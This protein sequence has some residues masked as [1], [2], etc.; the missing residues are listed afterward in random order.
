MTTLK[1]CDLAEDHAHNPCNEDRT[2]CC[3]AW[4]VNPEHERA[5]TN[6][7][8]GDWVEQ[9][10]LYLNVCPYNTV[11]R[12]TPMRRDYVFPDGSRREDVYEA[13]QEPET[14]SI[15]MGTQRFTFMAETVGSTDTSR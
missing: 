8:R 12:L 1:V 5:T 3:Y 14:Q 4:G 6:G 10:G 7:G 2:K 15:R 9:R 11:V 13:R